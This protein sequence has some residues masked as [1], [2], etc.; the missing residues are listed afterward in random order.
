MTREEL[1][2]EAVRVAEEYRDDGY[3][4]TLRQLY[5]QLVAQGLIPNSDQSYKRVGDTLGSARLAGN[6]D[7]DLIVD[8]GRSAEVSKHKEVKLDVKDAL[9]EAGQYLRAVPSWTVCVDRWFGQPT[10][11][12][13]WV[14]KD[15]LSGVFERPCDDLG[16]GFFA[17]KGYPSHSAL[18]QWLRGLQEARQASQLMVE[19]DEGC[20]E[21][22]EEITEAVVLYF[23]D[24]DPDG[25]QIPRSALETLRIFASVQELSVPPIRFVRCALNMDQIKQYNP[26]PF[27]AKMTSSRFVGY[28]K[29]HQTDD[30]WELDALSPAVLDRMIRDSV[31]EY[32]EPGTHAHWQGL[33]RSNRARLKQ[34]MADPAWLS[35]MLR[36]EEDG[37]VQDR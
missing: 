34:R 20:T 18:W 19:D 16:V 25:W 24:H 5:Y 14:E 17:C 3:T 10:H 21:W 9:I 2:I 36:D 23:G 31:D 13:V 22:P 30:A 6:F 33:A 11:V 7:M 26:P 37:C 12:S 29:E 35:R 8:R 32:W 1:L 4:L 27:P 28:Q 15:A